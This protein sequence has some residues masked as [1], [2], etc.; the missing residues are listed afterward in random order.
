MEAGARYDFSTEKRQTSLTMM[1]ISLNVDVADNAL[2]EVVLQQ[3]RALLNELVI[4]LPDPSKEEFWRAV[5]EPT[6][7][8][9]VLVRSF[10]EMLAGDDTDGQH[11][12]FE[13][14]I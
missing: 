7:P 5:Q 11:R 14:I 9:E 4:A 10:R 12:L 6:L 1:S 8:I 3:R 2:A 13:Q